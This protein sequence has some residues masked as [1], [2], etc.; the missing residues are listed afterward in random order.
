[1]KK[2]YLHILA[3]AFLWNAGA[4]LA[5]GSWESVRV[6]DVMTRNSVEIDA[7][8][9]MV[10]LGTPNGLYRQNVNSNNRGLENWER[11]FSEAGVWDISIKSDALW[12]GTNKGIYFIDKNTL[13]STHVPGLATTSTAQKVQVVGPNEI[14]VLTGWESSGKRQPGTVFV[15]DGRGGKQNFFTELGDVSEIFLDSRNHVWA[16]GAKGIFEYANGAWVDQTFDY[17]SGLYKNLLTAINFNEDGDGNIWAASGNES[18]YH[19]GCASRFDGDKWTKAN[20]WGDIPYLSIIAAT[21]IVGGKIWCYFG[22]LFEYDMET[23]SY[24]R[25]PNSPANTPYSVDMAISDNLVFVTIDGYLLVY[26]KDSQGASASVAITGQESTITTVTINWQTNDPNFQR[27]ELFYAKNGSGFQPVP[28]LEQGL[29]YGKPIVITDP[30]VSSFLFDYIVPTLDSTVA[31]KIV[32]YSADGSAASDSRTFN[33]P[34]T[35]GYDTDGGESW[36]PGAVCVEPRDFLGNLFTLSTKSRLNRIIFSGGCDTSGVV[37]EIRKKSEPNK[38]GMR[39]TTRLVHNSATYLKWREVDLTEFG[40]ELLA[41]EYYIGFSSDGTSQISVDVSSGPTNQG[42]E[43]AEDTHQLIPSIW[44]GQQYSFLLRLELK[45]ISGIEEDDF[46]PT[47]PKRFELSQNFPNPFN[48]STSFVFSLPLSEE[49][50]IT[51]VDGT[52]REIDALSSGRMLAGEHQLTWDGKDKNG[53]EAPSG[54]YLLVVRSA[55]FTGVK[56]MMLVR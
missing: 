14:W 30:N 54:V 8:S 23:Y 24:V 4:I 20:N 39:F 17:Q 18:G 35:V 37:V 7:V 19:G 33:I 43:T 47:A 9:G 29:N 56:K 36:Y 27:I 40:I 31:L 15:L 46:R 6:S 50:K 53:A 38:T 48:S 16:S 1:M 55:N 32:E 2:L 3:V 42:Y 34:R 49:V 45:D 21:R 28:N 52:G 13:V 22:G 5:Q 44:F 12:L 11:I 10:Y 25:H 51:V 41:G 26:A